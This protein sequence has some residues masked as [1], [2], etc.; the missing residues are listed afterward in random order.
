MIKSNTTTPYK[1]ERQ[2]EIVKGV[3]EWILLDN[4]P[5]SAPRKKGVMERDKLPYSSSVHAET[6]VEVYLKDE[7]VGEIDDGS[8]TESE[9]QLNI[10]TTPKPLRPIKDYDRKD[11]QKLKR[12]LPNEDEWKLI[13]E[14][15]KTFE[16]FD[17]AME[18]FSAEK[19]PTLSV[20][21]LIIELLKFQFVVDPNLPLVNDVYDL[22]NEYESNIDSDSEDEENYTQDTLNIQSTIAQVKLKKMHPWS[23]ELWKETIRI[24]HKELNNIIDE[25]P[26][27]STPSN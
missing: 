10:N 8:N 20:V 23:E 19:Y 2:K 4:E 17:H 14:L 9:K 3:I 13:E 26:T 24:C 15:V 18:T 7:E 12:Y 11:G 25:T 22:D 21:Y 5:L 6:Y 16:Q 27:Q 1:S